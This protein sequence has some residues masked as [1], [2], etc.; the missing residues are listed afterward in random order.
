VKANIEAIDGLGMDRKGREFSR[1]ESHRLKL[2]YTLEKNEYVTE[3]DLPGKGTGAV[4]I[5]GKIDL[6]VDPDNPTV[7]TLQTTPRSWTA[8]LAVVCLLA[9]LTIVVIIVA[10]LQRRSVL[11]TWQTGAAALA[12]VVDSHRSGIAPR[13]HV[14]RFTLADDQ[15][16]QVHSTLYPHSA[17]QL[18][19]GDE[20]WIVMPKDSPGRALV[21]D[22]YR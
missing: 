20:F 5:G 12:V 19:P 13:S 10:M 14:M 22:L 15:N 8:A 11:R 7:A 3:L 6:R 2:R 16:R 21:A 1:T 17:E 4:A 18:Y 9:P